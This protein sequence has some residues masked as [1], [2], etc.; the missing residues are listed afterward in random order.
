M[1]PPTR[2]RRRPGRPAAAVWLA[3][4]LAALAVVVAACADE[5][6][7]PGDPLRIA[8][9]DLPDAV[10]GE[11]YRADVVAVGGLRPYRVAL[12][13]GSL[14][15]GLSL[16]DGVVVGT[17]DRLGAYTFTVVVTDGNLASTFQTYEIRVRD[18][19]VPTFELTVPD[20]EVRGE[21]I[22][23]ARIAGARTWQGARVRLRW[24]DD[25]VTIDPDAVER[26]LRDGAAFVEGGDGRLAVDVVAWG[27]GVDG[28][29]ELFRVPADAS[30]TTLL[31]FDLEVELL[32]ADR[33]TF[34]SRR[35]GASV[36]DVRERTESPTDADASNAAADDDGE[37]TP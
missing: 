19:P 35:V 27:D 4:V 12:E 23:R 7:L 17:P 2:T 1:T 16:Q 14:P 36:E 13:E 26:S 6:P 37:G 28:D 9:N 15:P 29:A 21:T 33:H 34:V 3:A 18:V 30:S 24:D 5:A 20:T 11:E 10:V 32:Y 31:G 8:S 22:L 25:R